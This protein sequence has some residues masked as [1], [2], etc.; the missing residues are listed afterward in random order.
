[1]N[2]FPAGDAFRGPPRRPM[3]HRPLQNFPFTVQ[4]HQHF[5]DRHHRELAMKRR[6]SEETAREHERD[7]ILFLEG[8]V[9]RPFGGNSVPTQMP[10]ERPML[11][12]P[13][14][15][16][17][18][19]GIENYPL[20]DKRH[21]MRMGPSL[22]KEVRGR[23]E[24]EALKGLEKIHSYEERNGN[25]TSMNFRADSVTEKAFPNIEAMKDIV[26]F[27]SFEKPRT[28]GTLRNT[29]DY[30]ALD[31]PR[32]IENSRILE[33]HRGLNVSK[34]M[35]DVRHSEI[36]TGIN[37]SNS[38][39][40][41]RAIN[42]RKT[43]MLE[44]NP[45]SL[46]MPRVQF[47]GLERSV[48][49]RD[50]L[51]STESSRGDRLWFPESNKRVNL[52]LS[53]SSRHTENT[54]SSVNSVM[55]EDKSTGNFRSTSRQ[56]DS[57]KRRSTEREQEDEN[58]QETSAKQRDRVVDDAAMQDLVSQYKTALKELTFNSKPIITNLTIIAG[59]NLHASKAI[60]ATVCSHILEVPVE[61]TLPSLYLLD[62][63][64]KNISGS[65][66]KHFAVRLPEVFIK[67]YRQVDPSQYPAMQH[68][69]K[70]WRGVFSSDPL[71]E[72][73]SELQFNIL[74]NDPLFSPPS[75]GATRSDESPPPQQR[76]G[77][78]IHVNPKYLEAQRKKLQQ[79][80]QHQPQEEII[81]TLSNDSSTFHKLSNN[82]PEFDY[83]IL[84]DKRGPN[85][86][87][88]E[89]NNT[90]D[91]GYAARG[92]QKLERTSYR[93]KMQI[94]YEIQHSPQ[95]L[96]DAY[97]NVRGIRSSKYSA[98][99][100][101][102]ELDGRHRGLPTREWRNAEEEEYSWADVN[103]KM[104]DGGEKVRRDQDGWSHGGTVRNMQEQRH[105]S[106]T[107]WRKH[108]TFSEVDRPASAEY[109]T[110]NLPS[111]RSTRLP[112]RDSPAEFSLS[113]LKAHTFS[114]QHLVSLPRAAMEPPSTSLPRL[115][116]SQSKRITAAS[117]L[118]NLP[119]D[120]NTGLQLTDG[121]SGAIGFQQQ[122]LSSSSTVS[123]GSQ[124]HLTSPFPD[125]QPPMQPSSITLPLPN[126]SSVSV[127]VEG[128]TL[129]EQPTSLPQL[130]PTHP[131]FTPVQQ[132]SAV[133][134]S[135]SLG[136]KLIEPPFEQTHPQPEK[137]QPAPILSQISS[138]LLES[139]KR[140]QPVLS[141]RNDVKANLLIQASNAQDA[142][143]SSSMRLSTEIPNVVLQS[144]LQIPAPIG[145]VSVSDTSLRSSGMLS[146]NTISGLFLHSSSVAP[147]RITQFTSDSQPPTFMQHSE[148]LSFV[149]QP[150]SGGPPLPLGPPPSAG[151]GSLTGQLAPVLSQITSPLVLAPLPMPTTAVQTR[152]AQPPLPPGPPPH[153]SSVSQLQPSVTAS[154][155]SGPDLNS[156]LSS[157]VARGILSTPSSVSV[158]SQPVVVSS[159]SNGI[160]GPVP[161]S[162][163]PLASADHYK[164]LLLP[165]A[166][167]STVSISD[168]KILEPPS[169]SFSEGGLASAFDEVEF[170][171]DF[172]RQKQEFV[173]KALYSDFPRQC[174]TCGL[175]FKQQGEHSEHMDW[176]VSRNRRQ[177]SAKKVSRKWFVN[178]KEWLGGTGAGMSEVSPAFFP[179]VAA[180]VEEPEM[181]IA[182]P[183][184]ENQVT[185][186]LCGEPF[187]EFYSDETDE[188]MY[189]GA[190]YMN[191]PPEG[192]IEGLDKTCHGPIVHANCR[193][194]SAAASI[195][196]DKAEDANLASFSN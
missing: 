1:M 177:K 124:V 20:L 39:E 135:P 61:Q 100:S 126:F 10:N 35:D 157:L 102:Q 2:N 195:K 73:E 33:S 81:T 111:L 4:Q 160:L 104:P 122:L 86:E 148:P 130:I 154:M 15:R 143:E 188:W 59:E 168:S 134:R 43:D 48:A 62:S 187:E 60:A 103:P 56:K 40:Q 16:L 22:Q 166:A 82:L 129:N 74:G 11:A 6:I 176:H 193:S 83:S 117:G 49:S 42:S 34:V 97:G 196:A 106:W 14:K 84:S 41:L 113:G 31:F 173:I 136:Q 125:L 66:V 112:A 163:L 47:R 9:D 145:T 96:L 36:S 127:Q 133:S 45:K 171:P 50:K 75:T 13:E 78:G 108:G 88:L 52:Q 182:V 140:L 155:S 44:V 170:K 27:H 120:I 63:I 153:S 18:G 184:D 57:K 65:Y 161:S 110:E 70:T 158:S 71:R 128:R 194:E 76:P 79:S 98:S 67:A 30:G 178:T 116:P 80:T 32:K 7:R 142:A 77:H 132:L 37:S 121:Q 190:V 137:V 174:K 189:K 26:D 17:E 101:G 5:Q 183:A 185:C 144:S 87:R 115:P 152:I 46:D 119:A 69:F 64:V 25:E 29:G 95:A 28:F 23:D 3:G 167:L 90:V 150:V 123:S 151:L 186:A 99:T 68:L 94:E 169:K 105:S 8:H 131:H 139:L 107:G 12:F 192:F 54:I 141:E 179:E 181:V 114:N 138:G 58:S 147:A 172:L 55:E 180:K 93:D 109:D 165:P 164:R 38:V 24:Q 72:I 19:S 92:E 89:K 91:M 191:G 156:L 53:G 162:H 149:S 146:S 175:R 159:S 51:R 118:V 85:I 21:G